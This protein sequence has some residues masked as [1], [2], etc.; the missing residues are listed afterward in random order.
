MGWIAL[1]SSSLLVSMVAF[2]ATSSSKSGREPKNRPEAPSRLL[3]SSTLESL[4]KIFAKK[5][6]SASPSYE[7]FRREWL[8]DNEA[9]ESCF[10]SKKETLLSSS[11]LFVCWR[12]SQTTLTAR[13]FGANIFPPFSRALPPRKLNTLKL[14]NFRR[15]F[16]WQK[17]YQK[18]NT[19]LKEGYKTFYIL[20][21]QWGFSYI[22]MRVAVNPRIRG[23]LKLANSSWC[24]WTVQ[25]QSAN[26]L[27]NCWR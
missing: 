8:K 3:I 25:K 14:S 9:N 6:Y 23:K 1:I 2:T 12:C 10:R 13:R 24:E 5:N 27:A 26:T 20:P 21:Q 22:G 18:A 7:L 17:V 19:K 4:V 16:G 15:A 11:Q